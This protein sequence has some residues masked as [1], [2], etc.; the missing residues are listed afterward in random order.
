[1]DANLTMQNN[2]SEEEPAA[3]F[4][5]VYKL[6]RL[7]ASKNE[8]TYMK[9]IECG[10]KISTDDYMELVGRQKPDAR[11]EPAL[12]KHIVSVSLLRSKAKEY[13]KFKHKDEYNDPI[14]HR[15]ILE[16]LNDFEAGYKAALKDRNER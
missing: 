15:D 7:D 13:A 16:T 12:H 4:Q 5:R 14:Y 11:T 9:L 8:H 2:L 1:M 6:N 3:Y 10:G